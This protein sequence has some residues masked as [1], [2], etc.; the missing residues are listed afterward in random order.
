MFVTLVFAASCIINEYTVWVKKVAPI[1]FAIFSL[2]VNLCE[3]MI[4]RSSLEIS[5]SLVSVCPG[6]R[7]CHSNVTAD[8]CGCFYT[9][10][11]LDFHSVLRAMIPCSSLEMSH[12]LVSV[13]RALHPVHLKLQ[14]HGTIKNTHNFT[15][16]PRFVIHKFKHFLRIFPRQMFIHYTATASP[17]A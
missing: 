14:R 4:S 1:L 3:P 16:V 8:Y 12:S 17:Q 5:H 10:N 2:V 15:R 9:L 13:C 7:T 11:P 6:H